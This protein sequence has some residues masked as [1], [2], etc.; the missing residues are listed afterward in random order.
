MTLPGQKEFVHTYRALRWSIAGLATALRTEVSF[1]VD[2]FLFFIFLTLGL[3]LGET[4]V[5]KA[6]LV[7][8]L[9]VVLALDLINAALETVVDR[10]SPD[11]SEFARRAKDMASAAVFVGM[12]SV[13]VVWGLILVPRAL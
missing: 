8:P 5:E 1:R 9:F 11:Y 12:V 2:V 13:L 7:A 4:G 3:W 6:L 10:V